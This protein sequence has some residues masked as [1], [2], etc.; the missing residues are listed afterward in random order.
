MEEEIVEVQQEDRTIREFS[1]PV[2]PDLPTE[3]VTISA[4]DVIR[5]HKP[6]RQKVSVRLKKSQ[7]LLLKGPNGIGKS[8]LLQSIVDKTAK[9]VVVAPE[10]RIGYYRQD[11]STLD[12]EQSVFESLMT[13]M[14][15]KDEERM[16]KVAAGFLLTAETMKIR[17]G[18]LSEG[19]KG[20]LAFARL[21]LWEPGLLLLNE[22]TNHI[23]F[24]HIPVIAR[25]LD[26]YKGP[27]ILVSHVPEFVQMIR[28]DEELD[29]AAK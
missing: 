21:V 8:T 1:I 3:V 26:T 27:M 7:H 4:L 28:I 18:S 16:R 10:V 23:N 22:P 19:Q 11:F 9:G 6:K 17:V 12:Y 13:S 15:V 25:A 2:Q 14:K 20:L 5:D 29:L 24:R